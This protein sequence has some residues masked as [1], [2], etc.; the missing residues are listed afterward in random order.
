MEKLSPAR[1][2]PTD[3]LC[4]SAIRT[5][6]IADVRGYMQFTTEH[7]DV[8]AARLASR[9][10]AL[11]QQTITP[12]G[13]EVVDTRGDE[14]LA[15]FASAGLAFRA[16]LELQGQ[17]SH[18]STA[19]PSSPLLVGIGLDAGEAIP[20]GKEYRGSALNLAARLCSLARA[21]EVLASEGVVHLAG[22]VEGVAYQDRG[23]VELRGFTKPIRVTQL[24]P[25]ADTAPSPPAPAP[26]DSAPSLS[27]K[28]GG[29][30]PFALLLR[31]HRD[32]AELTQEQ[33]AERS[34]V[35]VRAI[36]DLERGAKIRPQRG[37]MQLLAE[38]LGLTDA[39][40]T[41]L[42]AAV[43]SR[44]RAPTVAIR[45]LDL[46]VG[47]F[48]GAVPDGP[49]VARTDEI[50]RIRGVVKTVTGGAGR[51]LLLAGEPG[52]G[53]T[54]LAQEVTLICRASGMHL[55]T[56]R[57][58]EPQQTVAYY[59]FLE[60][61]SRLVTAARVGLD[62]DP[63][64]RWPQLGP[65]IP[66]DLSPGH[67]RS[68]PSTRPVEGRGDQQRLFWAAAGLVEAL[69][70]VVPVAVALDDLHWADDSS[71][72]LFQHLARQLRHVPVL[73]VGMY[74][75]V[76]VDRSHPLGRVLRDLHREHL[77][78]EISIGQFGQEGTGALMVSAL[79]DQTVASGFVELVHNHTEGNAFFVQ[80]MV[81]ALVE[82][83]DVFQQGGVWDRRE[84]GEIMV[85]HTVHEAI[86]ER[87][88]RLSDRTQT[89]LSEASVLGQTFAF[90]ELH[91]MDGGP[92]EEIEE[93]LEEAARASVVRVG[94]ED[95]YTFNHA[96]TQR[97]L[98][99]GLPPRRRKR[100]HLAA[101]SA[102]EQRPER[103]RRQRVAELAWHFLQGGAG[104]QACRYAALAGDQ[105]EDRFAHREA[106]R[107]YRVA[108]DLAR[109]KGETALEADILEK[110]GRVRTNDGRY[111]EAQMALERA[112]VLY[113]QVSDREGEVRVAV[114]LGS[115]H[116]ATGTSEAGIARVQ[117]LL[118]RLEPGGRARDIAELYIVL[119]TLHFAT[120]RYREGLAAAERAVELTKNTGDVAA[121]AR[122]QTGQGTELLMLSCVEQGLRVLESAIQLGEEANDPYNLTRALNNA[123][124]GYRVQGKLA[125]S[126]D[127]AERSVEL[128]Q[129]I[130]NPWGLTISLH[131][132][133]AAYKLLGDWDQ[134]RAHLERGEKL[135]HTLRPSWW[136]TYL[137]LELGS[138]Y[139]D[140]GKREQ[141]HRLVEDALAIARRTDHL[142]GM[143]AGELVLAELDLLEG[144]AEP[145]RKRLEPLLDRPG[146]EELQVTEML[147]TLTAAYEASG[148][149]GRALSTVQ[150]AIRRSTASGHMLS[151]GS[152]QLVRGRLMAAQ[153]NWT[154]AERA[155]E[156]VVRLARDMPYPHLEAR[157]LFEWGV[158]CGKKGEPG[159]ARERLEVAL[160]IFCRLG[161]QPFIDRTEQM[162]TTLRND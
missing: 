1:P 64:Q 93:G 50:E 95:S 150:E 33:L 97:V 75:D 51:V 89:V 157:G 47:G 52:V 90:D 63:Q 10:A 111:A 70:R 128:Q 149:V 28:A 118:E 107:H 6:L 159:T 136:A 80:E 120:G 162:L 66:Q 101:G 92:E 61:V 94:E 82:R 40:R 151:L 48:L 53:K 98:Y 11:V 19:D 147:P 124:E 12:Y 45:S 110:L 8:A 49:L 88:S 137:L 18:E 38:G 123:A 113:R 156:E 68:M 144:R 143:R 130:Q 135:L 138:L 91:G 141:G 20:A 132:L 3:A 146:L 114:Q 9:F 161:A 32:A 106:E 29:L 72:D 73:L 15:V 116:R 85:P 84:G 27:G 131:D 39:E 14:A 23:P 24:V 87:L 60:V 56:G 16:A 46:P 65:L 62:V 36:S 71:L 31:R 43:P 126:R 122:A 22:R 59:P 69:A 81:R 21:G 103:I 26:D 152:A 108:L 112:V 76:E 99:Q 139:L 74:R 96:L 145:A 100:L 67:P 2:G 44:H 134:A 127:I 42:E 140:E 129:R 77:V 34:G 17:F 35:S 121:L 154:A 83:G 160:G 37:T 155:F 119:E 105:A 109:G 153:E 158:M 5:F 79:G 30:S 133:G 104:E 115:V 148:D 78:E 86:G 13:G 57:C 117:A 55:A 25:E 102:I 54:R 142:E 41:G 4:T 125:R 58:Y 7:G